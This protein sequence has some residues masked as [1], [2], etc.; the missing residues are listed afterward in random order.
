MLLV[1]LLDSGT[2]MSDF[3]KKSVL[4]ELLPVLSHEMLQ[5]PSSLHP[6]QTQNIRYDS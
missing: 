5:N 6:Q 4:A 1:L 3:C 2:G